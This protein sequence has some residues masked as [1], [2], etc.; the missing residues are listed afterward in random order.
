MDYC[1]FTQK[2][3]ENG[4]FFG[5][6]LEP[7]MKM[8]ERIG[9]RIKEIKKNVAQKGHAEVYEIDNSWKTSSLQQNTSTST[10]FSYN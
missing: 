4:L 10:T 1:I 7:M 6:D 9:H 8:I 2:E 5:N 3:E